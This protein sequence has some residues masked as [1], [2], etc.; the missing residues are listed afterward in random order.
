[1]LGELRAGVITYRNVIREHMLAGTIEEKLAAEKTLA[2]VVASNS[3]IRQS[4]E[5]M[6]TSPEERAL[7]NEWVATF[8]EYGLAVYEDQLDRYRGQAIKVGVAWRDFAE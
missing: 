5:A 6:I 4:Y 8:K 1:M 2:S 7:Y 3:K